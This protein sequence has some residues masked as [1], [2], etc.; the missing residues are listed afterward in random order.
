MLKGFRVAGILLIATVLSGCGETATPTPSPEGSSSQPAGDAGWTLLRTVSPTLVTE[1][2][3]V[4]AFGA[5][6]YLVSVTVSGAGADGCASPTLV[7]FQPSGTTLVAQ[8]TR[9][10][11]SDSC[12]VTSAVTYYV[13]LDRVLLPNS[14]V[15]IAIG[16]P[17]EGTGCAAPIPQRDG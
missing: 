2:I 5:D 12:A 16:E 7:G 15:R 8:I 14:I 13:A 10:P 3:A 4:A 17:C 11:T 6:Q 1:G 9:S